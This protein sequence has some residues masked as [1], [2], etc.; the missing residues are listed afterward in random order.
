MPKRRGHGEG[1]VYQRPDGRWTA[2]ITVGIDHEGKQR[3]LTL[4]GKSKKEVLEKLTQALYQQQN[5]G[6][7]EPSKITVEQWLNRWLTDYAKPHLRQSTWE[8]YETVLRLH[9]IPTLG[10]IPLKKLQ[11][12]DIQRLYASKLESGLSPTRVRYIHVVLHEAM[13]QARESGLLL[14]NP[15]EAAKPPRHPKKKVQPLNPEQVKRFLETAKQDPLYPAFLL[16]LGTGLRRGEILGLRW[17]DLDLQKGILQVRQSL[18]RTR[19]GLKFEEPKTEKSR[20][21]IPLPPS[22]V[23]A[24][25]RHKAWVNQ[26]KLILGPDYEDHDLVFPVENGRPRDPKGF[27]EYFNRLLD[28]AGLPHIRLHDL[29]HTHATLLLLEGVHPKVVQE[30]LGH[31]TVSITL[32]IYSHILPGLQE[33]AAERIDGLLQPKENSS[34]KEGTIK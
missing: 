31:S 9:V 30:R 18:I 2:Q 14:Q 19:E 11:P 26:N 23:A 22:V 29:R 20:R 10:S 1:T 28:K 8:S 25:K 6:F 27:A 34:P 3:R 24:L 32:D 33:K 4:Y 16:A 7:I 5:G 13:S 12:A 21:Q 17:Q 15:T